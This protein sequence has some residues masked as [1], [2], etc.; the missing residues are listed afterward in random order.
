MKKAIILIA[1]SSTTIAKEDYVSCNKDAPKYYLDAGNSEGL[2]Q[3]EIRKKPF[4]V[5]DYSG[6]SPVKLKEVSR[7]VDHACD[8][9]KQFYVG[10]D[11]PCA[12]IIATEKEGDYYKTCLEG[13]DVWSQG[14]EMK[15]VNDIKSFFARIENSLHLALSGPPPEVYETV[16]G[17]KFDWQNFVQKVKSKSY[18]DII[19][20]EIKEVKIADGVIWLKIL[21]FEYEIDLMENEENPHFKPFTIWI[22]PYNEE[23]KPFGWGY[24]PQ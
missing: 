22:R 15:R 5:Y 11:F 20:G 19:P 3:G 1:L 2:F 16:N 10:K 8:A 9:I 14:R 6:D 4:G 13:K 12:L 18:Q 7:D 24:P 21:V 17:K 23:G